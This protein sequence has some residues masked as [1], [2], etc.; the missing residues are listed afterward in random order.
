MIEYRIKFKNNFMAPQY[1]SLTD[2]EKE[3]IENKGTET[4]FTGE[5]DNF[6]K[7][8]TFIC[9][10]CNLPLFTSKAKFDA[11]CGW[12][13]FDDSFPDAL[14]RLTDADGERTE[15]ECSNCHAHLGHEFLGEQLTDKNV[16]ECVNSVSIK[17]MP[18]G[19]EMPEVIKGLEKPKANPKDLFLTG[20]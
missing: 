3:V 7:E 5:Y 16:R 17:F 2:E 4:P 20:E 1:N 8:G 14:L 9:R 19:A 10:R 13:A 15:I 6:Y 18:E 11:H 12:P